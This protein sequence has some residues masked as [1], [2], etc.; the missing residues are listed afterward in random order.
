MEMGKLAPKQIEKAKS[1]KT[2]EK[3]LELA[4]QEGMELTDEQLQQ[5]SGGRWLGRI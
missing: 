2:P 1:C 3:T 5:I 4:K